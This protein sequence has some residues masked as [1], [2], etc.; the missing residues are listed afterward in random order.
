[1]LLNF[2]GLIFRLY[3][4]HQGNIQHL[5]RN[6]EVQCIFYTFKPLYHVNICVNKEDMTES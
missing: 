5:Q 1:M 6:F 3:K 4:I 2:N